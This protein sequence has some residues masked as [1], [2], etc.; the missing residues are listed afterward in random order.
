M[1]DEDGRVKNYSQPP[2]ISRFLSP[3][4]RKSNV[5]FT[6]SW[7]FDSKFEGVAVSPRF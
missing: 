7:S 4:K 6:Q 5:M 2:A 1:E 3:P